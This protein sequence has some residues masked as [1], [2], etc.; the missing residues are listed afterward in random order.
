MPI[1]P[2]IAAITKD[3]C[4]RCAQSGPGRILSPQFGQQRLHGDEHI[5]DRHEHGLI[6]PARLDLGFAA[7]ERAYG[8]EAIVR[9]TIVCRPAQSHVTADGVEVSTLEDTHLGG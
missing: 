9:K 1:G 2:I 6:A 3:C 8:A 7:F 4:A 5:F